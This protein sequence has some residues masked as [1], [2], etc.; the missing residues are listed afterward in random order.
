MT[1]MKNYLVDLKAYAT[2][3]V[4][5]GDGTRGRIKGIGNLASNGSPLLDNVLL[6]EVLTANLISISQLCDEGL[7]VKFNNEECLVMKLDQEIVMRGSRSKDNYY[8][9]TYQEECKV[10]RCLLTKE[11][12]V[13]LWHRKLGHLN[14]KGMKRIISEDAVRGLPKMKIEEGKVCGECQ[15]G[16]QT[17][18][19]HKKLQHLTTTKVL[20]LLHRSEEH[21]SEL[22]SH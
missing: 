21:T 19:P 2:S 11:E 20:E 8:M 4:T 10:S 7:E 15:I 9:W 17:K 5:F 16:K 14:L 22:Q 1:G 12:E 18:V 13:K 6:V 3:Y